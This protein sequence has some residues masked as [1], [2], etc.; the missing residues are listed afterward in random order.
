MIANNIHSLAGEQAESLATDYLMKQGYHILERN[1]R[2][3][4]GEIDI[5]A[6]DD[7]GFIF[8][9]APMASDR[10]RTSL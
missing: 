9:S 1:F 3:K 8:W 10:I 5:I 7:E 2:T 6:K 4:L